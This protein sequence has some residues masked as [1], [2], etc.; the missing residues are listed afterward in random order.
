MSAAVRLFSGL[1]I[2]S[3]LSLLIIA[4]SDEYDL[5]SSDTAMEAP[6]Q[7][8]EKVPQ[9]LESHHDISPAE[10]LIVR[11]PAALRGEVTSRQ[12]RVEILRD[13]ADHFGES[14]RMIANRSAQLEDMLL[15]INIEE[16]A[17]SLIN[18]FTQLPTD[19]TPYN[20]SAY[21]Q[22]YF[23]L[24]AQGH[25]DQYALNELSQLK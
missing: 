11:S 18:R 3:S 4:C 22:Y 10:W 14:P 12:H 23:N 24:R 25:D 13:A 9:W 15:E 6:Q 1:V 2:A 19:D 21:C 20:F 8:Q 5:S 17:I 16:S 7:K